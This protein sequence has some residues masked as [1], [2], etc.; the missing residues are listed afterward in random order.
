MRMTLN[1]LNRYLVPKI[2]P[3]LLVV[4]SIPDLVATAKLVVDLS[5]AAGLGVVEKAEN[6][7]ESS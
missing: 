3:S 7:Q 6:N 5:P 1:G 2:L 4:D